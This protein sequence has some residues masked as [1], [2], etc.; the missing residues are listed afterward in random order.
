[1]DYFDDRSTTQA[2]LTIHAPTPVIGHQAQEGRKVLVELVPSGETVQKFTRMVTLQT[3]PDMGRV[4]EAAFLSA[5]AE[6]Y[7]KSCPRSTVSPIQIGTQD[8]GV[9]IDCPKHPNTG[10]L[11][12]VFARAMNLGQDLALVQITM[13]Y[14][15]MPND[16]QWARDY[17]SRVKVR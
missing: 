14:L 9:R 13:K 11:E 3:A 7:S 8:K 4:P 10:Q 15:P 1:M 6:R 2:A 17:L 5:F 16:S 12:A